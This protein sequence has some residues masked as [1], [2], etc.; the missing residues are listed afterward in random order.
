MRGRTHGW[1]W[2][3]AVA[4]GAGGCEACKDFFD[5]GDD[6]DDDS[7]RNLGV[8]DA[9][10]RASECRVGLGC[11]GGT[12]QPQG[13]GVEGSTCQL[14]GDCGAGLYCARSRTCERAGDAMAGDD[15]R[16]TADCAPGLVCTLEGLGGRCRPA[17]SADIDEP[18]TRLLD[19]LAGLECRPGR[20]GRPGHCINPAPVASG[21]GGS[22]GL[23]P[24]LPFW[25]GERCTD[26]G[27]PARALFEVPRFDG[28]D[29][30]FYRLPFPNDIRRRPDGL[31]LRGHP[32]PATVLEV[33]IIDRY[34]RASE[35]DL[36][37]FSLN[38]T[39]YFRFSEPYDWA[40]V[41]GQLRI[42]DVTPGSPDYG[43][44]MAL[45]W[46]TTAGPITRYLCEDWLALRVPHGAPLRP[47]T[48]YAAIVGSG[49]RPAPSVGG[50][51]ARSPDL[52]AVL[53]STAPSD[54]VLAAA[55]AAYAPLRAWLADSGTDPGEVLNA[56]VFTTQPLGALV[57]ALRE[58]IRG[59]PAPAV[60]EAVLCDGSR[61]SPCDDGTPQ[62]ACGTPVSGIRE[63]HGRIELPIFQHGRAPYEEPD[64]GGG[65]Q[66]DASGRP[67]VARTEAVCFGLALPDGPTPAGGWPLLIHAHGTGG[68][69]RDGLSWSADLNAAVLG[70]DLPQHGARRGGSRRSP[71]VLFFNFVNPPAARDNVTQGAADLLALV[72]FAVSGRIEASASPTGEAIAF[73]RSRIVL[74]AHS[75]G[76]THAA[77]IVPHEPDLRAV[78]FSGLGGDLTQSLLHKREP[79][80]IAALLPFALLD[81]DASGALAAGDFHPALALFQG[82]FDAVD[83]V[84][85][86]A[87]LVHRR[88]MAGGAPH[89]FMT[90]GLGDS[91]S[92]EP[93]MQAYA[94]AAG[95]T[96]VRPVHVEF[97]LR[98]AD[99]PLRGNEMAASGPRTVGLRQYR[100][101]SGADGHFVATSGPG[102]A[103]VEAFLRAALAGDV[104]SI[105]TP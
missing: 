62:R 18:C 102:R 58:V 53:G 37:G 65:L 87:A 104:P 60:G 90:Y 9:C 51:F 22:G 54:P 47:A 99:P 89:V 84:N 88:P 68:S 67:V 79:V 19:C 105:G 96:A 14:T 36:R 98:A 100:P 97:G 77:L 103:D 13:L 83:A 6:G 8:G 52:D 94:L 21:D 38:P 48:T 45:A 85:H 11:I 32:S 12:C 5:A 31:D 27:A 59:R 82:Y 81:P 10:R 42:V 71:D 28:S 16:A 1:A 74:F 61:R 80:D 26:E 93:T 76:A 33:D 72:H 24:G 20:D 49:V 92:P 2:I 30:D 57:P 50:R 39:I 66:L 25:P 29:G 3:V 69:F 4:V 64:D 41:E 101:E 56:A 86:A 15:C 91:F 34:L 55:H 46:L 70:I 75:Q 7:P 95:L 17:G 63:I 78:V 23:V 40:S 35:R 44:T 73:D 43:R